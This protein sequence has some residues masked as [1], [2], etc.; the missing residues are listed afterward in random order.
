[1]VSDMDNEINDDKNKFNSIFCSNF[2]LYTDVLTNEW[3]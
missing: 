3:V 1:M 2:K